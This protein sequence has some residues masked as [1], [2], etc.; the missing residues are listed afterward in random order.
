MPVPDETDSRRYVRKDKRQELCGLGCRAG[1]MQGSHKQKEEE[2]KETLF[3][4]VS[5]QESV[6]FVEELKLPKNCK[7]Q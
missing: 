3:Y 1:G 6:A 2:K 7:L 5:G 4:V